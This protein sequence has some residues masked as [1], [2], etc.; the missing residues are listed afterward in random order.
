[1]W[2]RTA[3]SSW[4]RVVAMRWVRRARSGFRSE[5]AQGPL[6]RVSRSASSS[7]SCPWRAET[8]GLLATSGVAT[9]AWRRSP[10]WPGSAVAIPPRRDWYIRRSARSSSRRISMLMRPLCSLAPWAWLLTTC[11]RVLN[12]ARSPWA[13]RSVMSARVSCSSRNALRR[14]DSARAWAL[15]CS[16]N[17][18]TARFTTRW[19]TSGSEPVN[20]TSTTLV[21]GRG[22]LVRPPSRRATAVSRSTRA[23][24]ARS[25]SGCRGTRKEISPTSR[26]CP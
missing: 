19:A 11:S 14:W 6:V 24:V 18:M 10:I 20:V 3:A 15:E 9:M 13:A 21:S 1:M 5:R 22:S 4:P 25:T 2:L 17:T 7:M 8:T 16:W 26:R 23:K 12:S